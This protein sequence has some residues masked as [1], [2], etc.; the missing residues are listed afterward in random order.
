[1]ARPISN[2]LRKRVLDDVLAGMSRRQAAIKYNVSPSFAVKLVNKHKETGD[3]SPRK[4]GGD[5][6]S[7]IAPYEE[8][9]SELIEKDKSINL[10]EIEKQL[11]S[12]IER[13]ISK[14]A[15]DRFLS[16][17]KIKYKKNSFC[18]RARL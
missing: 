13:T 12:K 15:V 2:D 18:N 5:T 9:I 1:M 6:R 3:Y 4:M 16:K 7:Y 17:I 10:V 14:S 8:T 11:E